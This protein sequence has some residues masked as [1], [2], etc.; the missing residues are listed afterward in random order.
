MLD[1]SHG[2]QREVPEDSTDVPQ[3]CGAGVAVFV[4]V[5][6]IAIDKDE[7]ASD[8]L[9]GRWCAESDRYQW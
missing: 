4:I 8:R 9:E 6:A 3:L 7:Q 5:L 2:Y 1:A